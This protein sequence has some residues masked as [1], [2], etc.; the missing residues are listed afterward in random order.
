M[1]WAGGKFLNVIAGSGMRTS[2][3]QLFLYSWKHPQR[4]ANPRLQILGYLLRTMI[5]RGLYRASEMILISG[6]LCL[7]KC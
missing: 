6:V 3:D 1:P 7:P 5:I 4:P 2:S